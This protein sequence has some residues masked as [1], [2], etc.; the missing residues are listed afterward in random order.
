MDV[1]HLSAVLFRHRT[2]GF[3]RCFCLQ[4]CAL[5]AAPC[6]PAC[7]L[8]PG[9][10]LAAGTL[11]LLHGVEVG[12]VRQLTTAPARWCWGG[13]RAVP[14]Q[15]PNSPTPRRMTGNVAQPALRLCSPSLLASA[16]QVPLSSLPHLGSADT[17]QAAG[18][19]SNEDLAAAS[20]ICLCKL[21]Y[22]PRN[23]ANRHERLLQVQRTKTY[24]GQR[25]QE[26]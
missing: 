7:A 22:P 15:S 25:K 1:A 14:A 4:P 24:S 18:V 2:R 20:Q 12:G 11:A 26:E 3:S 13:R 21:C 8:G 16:W 5:K 19:P 17:D 10:H 9:C 23:A 6:L